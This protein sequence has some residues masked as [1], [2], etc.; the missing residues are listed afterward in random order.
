MER[1]EDLLK[2]AEGDAPA[3]VESWDPPYCGDIGLEIAADGSWLY[4]ESPIRRPGMVKLFARVLRRDA[5]GRTYLVTPTERVD[6]KV[7][8]APFVA[9]AMEATGHGPAQSLLFRTNVDDIV[10][11]GPDHPIR[12]TAGGA[13]APFKPYVHVRGRLEA[14]VSR[15]LIYDIVDLAEPGPGGGALG[16][17]SGGAF[18]PLPEE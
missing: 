4:Q 13:H 10:R 8:D 2:T 1:L 5:D 17:W 7:A 3:P 15:A 14:L 16:L 12:F 18:F 9:V 11:C 6:V